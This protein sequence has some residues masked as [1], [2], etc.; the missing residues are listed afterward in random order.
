MLA[1]L[2]SFTTP[3]Q[4]PSHRNLQQKNNYGVIGT[5][6][7]RMRSKSTHECTS[8]TKLRMLDR[9]FANK[10]EDLDIN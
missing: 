9:D 2:V 4:T 10:T 3:N 5:N 7:H 6:K 8:L 1:R